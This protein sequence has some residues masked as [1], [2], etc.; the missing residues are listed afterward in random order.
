[1]LVLTPTMPIRGFQTGKKSTSS[2]ARIF[3]GRLGR[4]DDKVKVMKASRIHEQRRWL[5]EKK[6][7]KE[8]HK[9]PELCHNYDTYH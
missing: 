4:A 9:F 7:N 6:K 2:T 8:R 3:T 1:M 5:E